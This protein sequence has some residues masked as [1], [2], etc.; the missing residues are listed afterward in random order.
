M[1]INKK[2]QIMTTTEKILNRCKPEGDCLIWQGAK[3][4][5]GYGMCRHNG[6]MTTTT[7]A[8]G[9]ETH[10]DPG[11]SGKYKFTHTC[12][13]YLCCNPDHIVVTTHEQIMNSIVPTRKPKRG[14]NNELTKET[15][16]AIRNEPDSGWGTGTRLA[17]KYGISDTT[18]GKIRRGQAYKWIQ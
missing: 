13:N 12:G 15:V 16:L 8:V 2:G 3:H 7:R 6:K 5:Q 11:D 4:R 17:K 1:N 10:G 14:T 9:L 18:V